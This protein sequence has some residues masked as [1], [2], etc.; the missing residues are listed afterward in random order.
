MKVVESGG[1]GDD[2]RQRDRSRGSVEEEI[3]A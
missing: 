1:F 2:G 3:T